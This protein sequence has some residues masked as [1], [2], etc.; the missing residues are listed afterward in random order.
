MFVQT[1]G[2]KNG[3]VCFVERAYL[4]Y[5]LEAALILNPKDGVI[6]EKCMCAPRRDVG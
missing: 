1:N 6:V 3:E 4:V 2:R 5:L